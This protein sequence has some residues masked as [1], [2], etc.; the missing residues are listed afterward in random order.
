VC[1]LQVIEK[2]TNAIFALFKKPDI[3]CENL[4]KGMARKLFFSP[5]PTGQE[6]TTSTFQLTKF[7]TFLGHVAIQ[8]LIHLDGIESYSID[9]EITDLVSF[10]KEKEILFGKKGLLSLFAPLVVQICLN[11]KLYPVTRN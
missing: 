1:R 8:L 9:D 4:L 6:A 3:V 11:H 10:V 5:Q 2:A 7:V